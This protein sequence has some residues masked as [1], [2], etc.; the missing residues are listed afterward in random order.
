ME[1]LSNSLEGWVAFKADVF[2]CDSKGKFKVTP[3][4]STIDGLDIAFYRSTKDEASN[5][6]TIR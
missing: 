1:E 4:E 2:T 5:R 3:S 6:Y